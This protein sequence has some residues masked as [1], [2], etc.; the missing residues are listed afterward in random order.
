MHF[1]I[2]YK[3]RI[4]NTLYLKKNLKYFPRLNIKMTIKYLKKKNNHNSK[5]M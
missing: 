2:F 5:I 4:S 1:Q 3:K